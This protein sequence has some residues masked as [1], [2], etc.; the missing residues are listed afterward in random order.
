M[1]NARS[2][3]NKLCELHNVLYNSNINCCIVTESWLSGDFSNGELDPENRFNIYRCDRVTVETSY[4]GGV[5]VFVSRALKSVQIDLNIDIVDDGF[6]I[7]IFDIICTDRKLRLVSIYRQPCNGI[8]AYNRVHLLVS[9][10]ESNIC[11]CGPTIIVGDLNFPKIDWLSISVDYTSTSAS[12]LFAE[13]ILKHGFVESVQ[14]PTREDNLLDVVFV[15]EPLCLCDVDVVEPFSNSDHCTVLFTVSLHCDNPSI[16]NDICNDKNYVDCAENVNNVRSLINP[17]KKYIWKDAD[18]DGMKAYLHNV[19]WDQIVMHN[20]EPNS[21]WQAFQTILDEAIDLYVPSVDVVDN[22]ETF[23]RNLTI[24]KYPAYIKVLQYRKRCLWRHYRNCRS[25]ASKAR[26]DEVSLACKRAIVDYEKKRESKVTESG[27]TGDFYKFVNRKLSHKSGVGALRNGNEFITNDA[28]KAEML[29]SA[30]HAAQQSDNGV[31][32]EF[33]SRNNGGKMLENIS[34]NPDKIYRAGKRIKP[35]LTKDPEGY[36]PYMLSRVL[37]ALSAPLSTIFQSFMSSG[38]IPD[39][40]RHSVI[41]PIFKKGLASDPNNYRPVA[42]TSI[43]S[44]LMERV[45]TLD[46]S[47]FLKESGLISKEQH[48]FVKSRCTSTNLLES[49]NDW[50]LHFRSNSATDIIFIDYSKAFEKVTHSKL[51]RKLEGYGISGTLLIFLQNFLVNRSQCTR[52]GA[53]LSCRVD[54]KSGVIQGSCIGPLLFVIFIN[55]II[56]CLSLSTA[57][58]LYADDVKLYTVIS[59]ENDVTRLQNDINA[60]YHWSQLWQMEIS[61][62]KTFV[63]PIGGKLLPILKHEYLLDNSALPTVTRARDLGIIVDCELTFT[64][65]INNIVSR[66]SARANLIHRCFV[67]RDRHSLLRAFIVYVRPILEYGSCV[68]SPRFLRDIEAVESVQRHF[69]KRLA[70]LGEVDYETRLNILNLESLE[71]RRLKADLVYTYKIL[72]G[73]TDLNFT[74]FF[75]KL[76]DNNTRGH[77]YRLYTPQSTN[78]TRSN[79]F[80]LRVLHAWNGLPESTTDFTNLSRFGQSIK[81]DYLVQFSRIGLNR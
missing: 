6:E 76:P 27:N 70:G 22:S 9:C 20:F 46:I 48:G 60:I 65:H 10:L 51:I 21:I 75:K 55:D 69:T 39:S 37:P 28:E 67:S 38:N 49:L 42:I 40:W 72:F 53:C 14:R 56:D 80:S 13:F 71:S 54:V 79:F 44:K 74:E 57:C 78:N 15:N 59:T 73:L 52:V 61:V 19:D 36:T 45:I 63:M 35:K 2:I 25:S 4:G 17:R 41:T 26:Y 29:N 30:F 11:K 47:A 32:P 68:W 34:F 77:A 62:C 66:A 7:V 12:R 64:D 50:T 8:V 18:Y 58:K 31:L 24:S 16:C 23:A 43:F 33:R 5:C 81:L 1:F 3:C